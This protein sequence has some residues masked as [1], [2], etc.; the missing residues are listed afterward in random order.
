[1][2]RQWHDDYIT[3]NVLIAEFRPKTFLDL[4]AKADFALRCWREDTRSNRFLRI[5]AS[6]ATCLE[7]AIATLAVPHDRPVVLKG[8][9]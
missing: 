8:R 2:L 6:V 3:T 1:M 5:G 9:S 4:L 7:Q